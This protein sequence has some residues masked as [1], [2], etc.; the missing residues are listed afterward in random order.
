MY[1]KTFVPLPGPEFAISDFIKTGLTMQS[2]GEIFDSE[3]SEKIRL[4][5][6]AGTTMM[7]CM[8]QRCIDHIKSSS[9]GQY[10]NFWEAH[11]RLDKDI[12]FCRTNLLVEHLNG[13]SSDD[14]E[15]YAVRVC[16]DA[17]EIMLHECALGKVK[18]DKLPN[19]LATDAISKCTTATIDI[20]Y[21]LKMC[22]E[23]TGRKQELFQ[24]LR[25]F[26]AWPIFT[27]IEL[28]CRM[29]HDGCADIT[30]YIDALRT[31]SSSD[32]TK[33][34]VEQSLIDPRLL[35]KADAHVAAAEQSVAMIHT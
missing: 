2:V 22:E 31:L 12:D 11:Y 10:Y 34:L 29:L 26:H 24:Q 16:M 4:S 27:A 20:V 25:S 23:M 17:T 33:V 28:C 9:R 7:S 14:P 8:F 6:F 32:T 30:P 18:N 13:N 21:S 35:G 1:G 19:G 15:S 3:I 5:S